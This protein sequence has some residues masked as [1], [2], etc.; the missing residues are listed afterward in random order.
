M[1]YNSWLIVCASKEENCELSS[2]ISL[3]VI[4]F[5]SLSLLPNPPQDQMFGFYPAEFRFM[6]ELKNFAASDIEGSDDKPIFTFRVSFK[7]RPNSII[8]DCLC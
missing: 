7:A 4:G 5:E 8:A 3:D 2:C 6:A 1:A